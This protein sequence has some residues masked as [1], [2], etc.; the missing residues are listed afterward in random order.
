MCMHVHTCVCIPSHRK[1]EG[2]RSS[3]KNHTPWVMFRCQY[4]QALTSRA[5]GASIILAWNQESCSRI[6]MI[7]K[8]QLNHIKLIRNL[9]ILYVVR[10]LGVFKDPFKS[11]FVD[12]WIIY[13]SMS[14]YQPASYIINKDAHCIN[15]LVFRCDYIPADANWNYMRSFTV[16]V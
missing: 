14:T 16:I 2:T 6:L 5:V 15:N 4:R 1:E 9:N 12:K 13:Q 8:T 11:A 3:F 10:L 7:R